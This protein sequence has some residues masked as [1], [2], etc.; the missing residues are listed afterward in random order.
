MTNN[1]A[2]SNFDHEK[3]NS[4]LR[5]EIPIDDLSAEE[6]DVFME[7]FTESLWEETPE[8]KAFFQERIA[9]G[10]GVGL[11]GNDNLIYAK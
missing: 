2:N 7:R 5:G 8:Q 10:L 11:D 9:K 6:S 1:S 4:A 3:I